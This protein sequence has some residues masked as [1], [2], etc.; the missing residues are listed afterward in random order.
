MAAPLPSEFAALVPAEASATLAET[1]AT[2]AELRTIMLGTG[3]NDSLAELMA[4]WMESWFNSD[5]EI[6]ADL[7]TELCA[8]DCVQDAQTNPTVPTTTTTTTTT[9]APGS[10]TTSTTTTSTT[11]STSTTAAPGPVVRSFGAAQ[12]E[13]SITWSGLAAGTYV[14][15]YHSG[16]YSIV[17]PAGSTIFDTLYGI[18][19][20]TNMLGGTRYYNSND[21]IVAGQAFNAAGGRVYTVGAGGSVTLALKW[22]GAGDYTAHGFAFSLTKTS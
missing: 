21:A 18:T 3:S 4:L 8:L 6:T 2:G 22:T 9:T 19:D 1:N 16:Y 15:R 17:P 12:P 7:R 11:T 20:N 10:T 13:G 5:G 14:L